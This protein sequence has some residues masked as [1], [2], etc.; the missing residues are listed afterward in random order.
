MATGLTVVVPA[1]NEEERLTMTVMEVI[2]SARR[3]LRAYE[4]VIVNDG[5]TDGTAAA[6]DALAA[7]LRAG[8][9]RTPCHESR[10]RC[11]VL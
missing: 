1:W 8:V 5:S 10:R 11:R 4:I 6:A 2:A 7:A 9:G 3:Y